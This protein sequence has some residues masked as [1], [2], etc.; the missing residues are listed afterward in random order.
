MNKQLNVDRFATPPENFQALLF[1]R[2]NPAKN[3]A[4][5]YYLGWQPTLIDTG[6]V[7]RIYGRR[8]GWQRVLSP[9]PFSTL[10][11]AWPTLRRYIL[12]RLRHNYQ[13]IRPVE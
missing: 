4:R 3:E 7:V 9:L 10:T 13:I 6:A 11:E 1:E 12:T 2:V 5:F 8:G